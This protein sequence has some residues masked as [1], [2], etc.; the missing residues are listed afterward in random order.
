MFVA[1][2][3]DGNGRGSFVLSLA[4]LAAAA[5]D[6]DDRVK[7]VEGSS[8][9]GEPLAFFVPAAPDDDDRSCSVEK[10]LT[11]EK[12]PGPQSFIRGS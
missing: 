11:T 8:S 10:K 4:S 12:Q 9:C 3:P 5:L 2:A 7:S 6:D 1:S